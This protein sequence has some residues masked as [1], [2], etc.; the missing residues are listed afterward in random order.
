MPGIGAGGIQAG[1]GTTLVPPASVAATP[2]VTPHTRLQQPAKPAE[3]HKQPMEDLYHVPQSLLLA[4]QHA[5][6][7]PERTSSSM[8]SPSVLF[9]LMPQTAE[10]HGLLMSHHMHVPFAG[11]QHIHAP[12]DCPGLK[13]DHCS[14]TCTANQLISTFLVHAGVAPATPTSSLL[15]TP[16]MPSLNSHPQHPSG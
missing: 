10:Q 2:A 15:A 7:T 12:G 16:P 11:R 8:P 14:H 1:A 9:L 4:L 3:G 13:A 6:A 5:A